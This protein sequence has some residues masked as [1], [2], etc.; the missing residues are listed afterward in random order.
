MQQKMQGLFN[1]GNT[2]FSKIIDTWGY[3]MDLVLKKFKPEKD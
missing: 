2:Q 1:L 3:M